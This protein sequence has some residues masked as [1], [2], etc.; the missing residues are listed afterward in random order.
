MQFV[1]EH[2]A[3]YG[4]TLSTKLP[5]YSVELDRFVVHERVDARWKKSMKF[6][7]IIFSLYKSNSFMT[8]HLQGGKCYL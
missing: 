1:T 3:F 2:L 7:E 4:V 5:H 6:H 8:Y